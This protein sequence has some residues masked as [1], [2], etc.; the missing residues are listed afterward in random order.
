MFMH[1]AATESPGKR[2][3]RFCC[4]PA[5]AQAQAGIIL[6]R[7]DTQMTVLVNVSSVA[8]RRIFPGSAAARQPQARG[9]VRTA[10]H[11]IINLYDARFPTR[12]LFQGTLPAS[13]LNMTLSIQPGT[14]PLL[15]LVPVP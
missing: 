10:G 14:P 3:W 1:G 12:P 9:P 5:L 15:R 4:C 7:N 11:Q 6:L 8:G 2:C 13:P